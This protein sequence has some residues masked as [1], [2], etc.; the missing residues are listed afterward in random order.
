MKH[1]ITFLL[2]MLMVFTTAIGCKS[3]PVDFQLDVGGSLY[4]ATSHISAD[5]TAHVA[6]VDTLYFLQSRSAA[7]LLTPQAA[8]PYKWLLENV[9]KPIVKNVGKGGKYDVIVTGYISWHGLKFEVNEHWKSPDVLA[10]IN[11]IITEDSTGYY[12]AQDKSRWRETHARTLTHLARF[13]YVG[14]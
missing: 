3:E 11:S 8:A 9:K 2:C 10:A 6:N 1:F 7:T 5:V 12:I 13:D 4:E 14:Y